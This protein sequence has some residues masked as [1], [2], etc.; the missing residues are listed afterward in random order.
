MNYE[1]VV[2]GSINGVNTG[3]YEILRASIILN[4]LAII[5]V[6]NHPSGYPAT[7]KSDIVFTNKV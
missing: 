6:H 5:L 2:T 1:T 3:I 4:A 7:S